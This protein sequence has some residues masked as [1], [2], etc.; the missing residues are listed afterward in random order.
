MSVH[1][2]QLEEAPGGLVQF[3]FDEF[4]LTVND[5]HE[6]V[7]P[8]EYTGSDLADV[9]GALGALQLKYAEDW[10]FKPMFHSDAVLLGIIVD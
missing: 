8:G 3:I 6:D 9:G 4:S 1:D 5:D 10:R 2:M 7:Q